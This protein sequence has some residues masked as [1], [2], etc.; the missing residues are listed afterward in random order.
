MSLLPLI[1]T[2]HKRL[3]ITNYKP[4]SPFCT[5]NKNAPAVEK[6]AE[7]PSNRV[8]ALGPAERISSVIKPWNLVTF[9]PNNIASLWS[10][11]S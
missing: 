7:A 9:L 5:S 4:C 1:R 11:S 6:T 10:C 8:Y 3:S 2:L